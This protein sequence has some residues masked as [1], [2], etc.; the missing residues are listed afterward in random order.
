MGGG[1]GKLKRD[2]GEE[3]GERERDCIELRKRLYIVN[4]G[5]FTW[6]VECVGELK[7]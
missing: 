3:E 4:V 5:K 6:E 1:G 7:V 2:E